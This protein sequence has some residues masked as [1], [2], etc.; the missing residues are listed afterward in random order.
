MILFVQLV[1]VVVAAVLAVRWGRTITRGAGVQPG[2][3]GEVFRR[4]LFESP[5]EARALADRARP[6]WVGRLSEV[7]LAAL[8][9]RRDIGL[10]LA[11][12]YKHIRADAYEPLQLL[13]QLARWSIFLG[14]LCAMAEVLWARFGS[15]GLD[16]LVAGVAEQRAESRAILTVA[17]GFACAAVLLSVRRHLR[18]VVR[19]TLPACDKF[20]ERLE[21]QVQQRIDEGW[22]LPPTE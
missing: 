8:D 21:N 15:H 10:E 19:D 18:R 11:A 16:A 7:A 17:I 13:R 14:L 6:S 2:P 22:T 12:E 9:A 3:F 20:R 4:S 1:F 5:N